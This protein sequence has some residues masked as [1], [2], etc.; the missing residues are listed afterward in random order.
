[1]KKFHHFFWGERFIVECDQ[2]ALSFIQSSRSY[3]V[4]DWLQFIM[5][6]DME[7]HHKPGFLNILPHHLSHLYNMLDLDSRGASQE[8]K[9]VLCVVRGAR[10]EEE[11]EEERTLE[12]WTAEAARER[13]EVE[14]DEDELEEEEYVEEIGEEGE[15]ELREADGEVLREDRVEQLEVDEEELEGSKKRGEELKKGLLGKR[16]PVLEERGRQKIINNN[17]SK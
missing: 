1:L 11:R 7:V 12:G 9:S 16:E 2:K 15:G 6:F 14:E 4:L 10:E 13:W 5:E 3:M 17:Q 8:K